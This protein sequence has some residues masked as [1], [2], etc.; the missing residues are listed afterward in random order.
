METIIDFIGKRR[1]SLHIP[2]KHALTFP[3]LH[4][5]LPAWMTTANVLYLTRQVASLSLLLGV[6]E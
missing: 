6:P 4:L 1:L 2:Q 5:M 3:N